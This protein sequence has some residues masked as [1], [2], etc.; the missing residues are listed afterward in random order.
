MS[1][2]LCFIDREFFFRLSVCTRVLM[3]GFHLAQINSWACTQAYT[4]SACECVCVRACV[5]CVSPGQGGRLGQ[6]S[7]QEIPLHTH[8]LPLTDKRHGCHPS[9]NHVP[10]P[11]LTKAL[12]G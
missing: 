11:L 6:Q 5:R 1:S 3:Y 2:G 12:I 8:T 7:L 9:P 4:V 10:T